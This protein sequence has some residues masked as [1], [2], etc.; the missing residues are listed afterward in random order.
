MKRASLY[1]G[2]K[3]H[4][5]GG[6]HVWDPYLNFACEIVQGLPSEERE[7]FQAW[8]IRW[9]LCQRSRRVAEHRVMT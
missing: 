9:G 7:P 2:Q 6:A 5:H 4:L 1:N 3:S 8:A